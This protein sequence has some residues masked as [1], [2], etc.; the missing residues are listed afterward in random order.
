M[1]TRQ[2]SVHRSDETDGMSRV[3]MRSRWYGWYGIGDHSSDGLRIH[4]T[5]EVDLTTLVMLLE[6]TSGDGVETS[7]RRRTSR[8]VDPHGETSR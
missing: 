6:L 7:G 2:G 5:R 8:R 1:T 3:H 4:E